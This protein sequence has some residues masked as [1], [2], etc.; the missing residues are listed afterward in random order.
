LVGTGISLEKGYTSNIYSN[1][2]PQLSKLPK[3]L[4]IKGGSRDDMLCIIKSF[5]S[6]GKVY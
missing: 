1:I 4:N 6:Q 3:Y 2:G 5:F